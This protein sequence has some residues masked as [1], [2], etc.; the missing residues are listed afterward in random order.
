MVLYR[1]SDNIKLFFY[2]QLELSVKS[3]CLLWGNRVVI[4]LDLHKKVLQKL[5][6]CYVGMCKMKELA[7]SYFWWPSLDKDIEI[8]VNSCS[9][10]LSVRSDPKRANLHHWE[11]PDKPWHRVHVGYAEPIDKN[12]LLFYKTNNLM[13]AITIRC[14]QNSFS[15][16]GL[17]ISL[18]VDDGPCFISAELDDFIRV[19]GIHHIKTAVYKPSM[20]KLA[21]NMVKTF[22][23]YLKSCKGKYLQKQIVSVFV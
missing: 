15:R 11:W 16:F 8:L 14:L 19:N 12:Y 10:C 21:E 3:N 9:K 5:H 2:K 1:P 23:Y 4:P 6:L 17:P 18:V 7:C 20:N 22:K 13:S